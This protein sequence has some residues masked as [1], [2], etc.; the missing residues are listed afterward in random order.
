MLDRRVVGLGLYCLLG[1]RDKVDS[2]LG[3]RRW[4]CLQCCRRASEFCDTIFWPARI[5]DR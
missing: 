5:L 2:F 4:P 1:G 3:G